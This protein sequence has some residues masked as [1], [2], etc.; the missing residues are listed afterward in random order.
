M[1]KQGSANDAARKL[2]DAN[3]QIDVDISIICENKPQL[4]GLQHEVDIIN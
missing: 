4:Q 2:T 1:V 3:L